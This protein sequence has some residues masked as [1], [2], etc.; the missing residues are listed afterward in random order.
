M[1]RYGTVDRDYGI[2]L[3]RCEPDEDGPIYMLNL[4]KYR[5][6]AD[7]GG[8]EVGVSGREA[9]DR[10][11]PVDVLTKIGAKVVF[12]AE[13]L[14]A[15]EDWDRVAIVCYPTRRSFIEMQSRKDFQEKHVHKEAGMDHTIVMGTLPVAELPGRNKPNRMLLDVWLGDTPPGDGAAFSVEGTIL[16]DGRTWSGARFRSLDGSPDVSGTAAH[17]VLVLQPMIERWT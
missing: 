12:T 11:A 1:P 6:E 5:D 14:D 4:M 2:R 7:Y 15:S 13:V 17:Q 16:G 9:D 10:Y 8:T 3:A